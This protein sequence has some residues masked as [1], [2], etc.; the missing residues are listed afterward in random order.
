MKPQE[1][2]EAYL[3]NYRT[4]LDEDFWAFEEVNE[5][6]NNFES[7]LEITLALISS[8]N[9]EQELSYVAAGPVEDMLTMHGNKAME[10]FEKAIL[11]SDK[12]LE[13]LAGVWLSESNEVYSTWKQLMNKHNLLNV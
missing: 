6:C 5:A 8:A 7:G 4:R 9:N 13:A 1:L 10:A 12:I 3:K 11:N 2:A